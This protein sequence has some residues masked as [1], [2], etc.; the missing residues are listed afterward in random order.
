MTMAEA[1][2]G[3]N[4]KGQR[5]PGAQSLRKIDLK[6]CF[7]KYINKKRRTKD[8]LYPL[9]GVGGKHSDKR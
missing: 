8:D 4:K 2:Q 9:L 7:Y 6:K 5:P 3:E 1:V